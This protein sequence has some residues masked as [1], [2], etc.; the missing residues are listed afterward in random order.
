MDTGK[1]VLVVAITL[2]LVVA[3]NAWIY[4][5]FSRKNTIGQIEILQRAAR[6]L[7]NPWQSEDNDLQE[8]SRLVKDMPK[9]SSPAG[10][11]PEGITTRSTAENK[12]Q[13]EDRN[14]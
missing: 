7:K 4:F 2:I 5:A 9:P 3:I 8:L 1:A 12:R 6:Q 10:G 13:T 14:N 11:Q